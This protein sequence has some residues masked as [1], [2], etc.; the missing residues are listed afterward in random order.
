MHMNESDTTPMPRPAIKDNHPMVA[1]SL[2]D[3]R[4]IYVAANDDG[5]PMVDDKGGFVVIDPQT[6]RL[7]RKMNRFTRGSVNISLKDLP[8]VKPAFIDN[9]NK[10]PFE[11]NNGLESAQRQAMVR[12]AAVENDTASIV[13]IIQKEEV[14]KVRALIQNEDAVALA[15]QFRKLGRIRR[16]VVAAV[17]VVLLVFR[18]TWNRV[19]SS[20]RKDTAIVALGKSVGSRVYDLLSVGAQALLN[21]VLPMDMY[22]DGGRPDEIALPRCVAVKVPYDFS[23][24]QVDEVYV[25][26]FAALLESL[27][28]K[29]IWKYGV[30]VPVKCRPAGLHGLKGSAVLC[31][32]VFTKQTPEDNS[33]ESRDAVDA[34]NKRIGFNVFY[35]N[36]DN[37]STD[38]ST[39]PW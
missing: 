29:G 6:G 12:A 20:F 39:F 13:S 27:Y 11:V 23:S 30:S 24:E 10:V 9:P 22:C 35:L 5:T 37:V 2:A 7:R 14:A 26:R 4:L 33:A 8:P 34:L 15:E 16:Y 38:W 1:G 21:N 17:A 32:A 25:R 18:R 28:D 19:T 31:A 3:G 36:T